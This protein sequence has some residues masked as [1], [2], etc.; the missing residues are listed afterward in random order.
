MELQVASEPV[1]QVVG[2]I[3]DLIYFLVIGVG[4]GSV[5][6]AAKL[7]SIVIGADYGVRYLLKDP[8]IAKK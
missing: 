7:A 1:P 5:M 8:T 6:D 4:G 3:R 2:I